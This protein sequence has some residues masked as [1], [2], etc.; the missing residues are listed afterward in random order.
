MLHQAVAF[1]GSQNL[2]HG[3]VARRG[4]HHIARCIERLAA[5]VEHLRRNFRNA[6]HRARNVAADGVLVVE[7]LEQAGDEPPVRAVVVHF[8]LLPDDALL[9]GNGLLRKIRMR[10]HAQQHIQTFVQ[11][12]GSGE[13][14]AGAVKAGERIGVGTGLGVLCKGV[15]VL[16]LKHFVL[17]EMRHTGRQVHLFAAQPEVPVN[18]A[19]FGGKD[20]MGAGV[21]RHGP[22]NDGQAG[23]QG[24]PLIGHGL[25][26]QGLVILRHR[27]TPPS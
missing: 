10:H 5:V 22:H 12:L 24:L 16:V 11:L 20:D 9:F 15:T 8:D 23:R 7:T 25:L 4:Q 19:E 18:G 13:Q 3:G 27:Q 1:A 26:Q 2:F 6:L 14:I 17:K 21:A